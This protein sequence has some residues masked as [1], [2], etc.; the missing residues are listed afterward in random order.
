MLRSLVGS[1]MC[2]R[3]R[4]YFSHHRRTQGNRIL[5]ALAT[6]CEGEQSE[7]IGFVSGHVQSHS[8]P[9]PAGLVTRRTGLRPNW[10]PTDLFFSNQRKLMKKFLLENA[11]RQ[12]T[13]ASDSSDP[14]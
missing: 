7:H 1:E 2:I 14:N 13:R 6:S 9:F 11:G 3:D 10:V 8:P 12:S 5:H 4:Y